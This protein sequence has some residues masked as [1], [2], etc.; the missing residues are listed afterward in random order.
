[1]VVKNRYLPVASVHADNQVH[2]NFRL[3]LKQELQH[4]NRGLYLAAVSCNDQVEN[5]ER[6]FKATTQPDCCSCGARNP[7]VLHV[8]SGF[9]APD[10]LHSHR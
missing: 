9:C 10:Y 2:V 8:R 3:A 7:H 6:V 4:G 5:L 1:M